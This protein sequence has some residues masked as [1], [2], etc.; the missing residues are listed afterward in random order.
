MSNNEKKPSIEELQREWFEQQ[1]KDRE[2]KRKTTARI[3]GAIAIIAVI[4]FG[5]WTVIDQKNKEDQLKRE[6]LEAVEEMIV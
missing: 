6:V 3:I 5:C 1:K 2:Q 4:A